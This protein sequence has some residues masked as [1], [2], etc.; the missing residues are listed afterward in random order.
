MKKFVLLM[1]SLLVIVDCAYAKDQVLSTESGRYVF[2]QIS[3]YAKHQYMLDTKTGALWQHVLDDDNKT[4]LEQ[5]YYTYPTQNGVGYS[6][7]P[8]SYKDSKK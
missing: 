2:G 4:V 7:F 5:I 8:P 6:V 1:I 3:D